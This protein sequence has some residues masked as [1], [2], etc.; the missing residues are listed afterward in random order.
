MLLNLVND[1][2]DY[3]KSQ[4]ANFEFFSEFFD[5]SKVIKENIFSTLQFVI[6]QKNIDIQFNVYL[7]LK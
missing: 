3:S 4:N 6:E 5:L 7:E 1:L 2:L